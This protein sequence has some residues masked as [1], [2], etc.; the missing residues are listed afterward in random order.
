M[1][2]GP[3]PLTGRLVGVLGSVVQI[4]RAA[5]LHRAQR[6]AVRGVLTRPAPAPGARRPGGSWRSPTPPTR[7]EHEPGPH[8]ALELRQLLGAQP[9]TGD[10]R[11]RRS[12]PRPDPPA[13]SAGEVPV[14]DSRS[15]VNGVNSAFS[16]DIVD[17]QAA[18]YGPEARV[19]TVVGE[20]DALTAP[21]LADFLTA[22]LAAARV[23]VVDLDGVRFL[24]S[25]GL[26]VLFEV[27]EL[28]T[29]QNRR[30]R[31]VCN[32]PAANLTLDT[33]GLREHFTFADTVPNALTSSP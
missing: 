19:V 24:A 17:L 10:R 23:V 16:A 31:L 29:Q 21:L 32:S 4:L 13:I 20:I 18:A 22:Q 7:G 25:A 15:I 12:A 1:F 30:L 9:P 5:V 28:A 6:R 2:H 26:R 11:S 33:T 14:S 3:F 8:V 27:N